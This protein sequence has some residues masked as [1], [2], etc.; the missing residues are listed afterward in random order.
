MLIC[1]NCSKEMNDDD[2]FCA[3]CGM[4]VKENNSDNK[5][6][7]VFDGTIHKCPN[8]GEVLNSF[9]ANC[10][11]CG[12]ELRSVKN[13]GAVAELSRKLEKIE[14][15]RNAETELKYGKWGRFHFPVFQL[16]FLCIPTYCAF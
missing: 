6:K 15:K 9:A 16:T 10:P 3:N 14:M 4:Q 13:S 2:K 5:R 8:C 11:A 1:S 7:I 12:F